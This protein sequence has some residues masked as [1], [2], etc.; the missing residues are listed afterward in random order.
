MILRLVAAVMCLFVDRRTM[1]LDP[2]VLSGRENRGY[3]KGSYDVSE[4]AWHPFTA[5][6]VRN[7]SHA[8]A[9]DSSVGH[10]R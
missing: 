8:L 10:L 5:Y 4:M 9:I 1:R 6:P 3:I 7:A 2:V